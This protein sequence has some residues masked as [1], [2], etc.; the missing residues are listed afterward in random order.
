MPSLIGR[1]GGGGGLAP[2]MAQY[3][4]SSF[5][6]ASFGSR[7]F[8][9][10]YVSGT[11]L[12]DLSTPTAPTPATQAVYWVGV[13]YQGDAPW[14][15]GA[16]LDCVLSSSNGAGQVIETYAI[17]DVNTTRPLGALGLV[18]KM[19]TA[20]AFR[21]QVTNLD[22]AARNVSCRMFVQLIGTY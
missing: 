10:I 14:T 21:A 17:A 1:C 9:W 2:D 22:G 3:D 5:S 11:A 4:S 15:A 19:T 6:V 18:A 12:L 8:D 20:D 16:A 13:N 7:T